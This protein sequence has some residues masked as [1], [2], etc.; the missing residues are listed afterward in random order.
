MVWNPFKIFFPKKFVGI[1]IGTSFIKMVEVSKSGKKKELKNYGSVSSSTLFQRPFRTFEKSTLLLSSYDV[2]K[3]ILAVMDEAGIKTRDV[4]FSIPDFSTFFTN[5]QLPP[6]GK[7]ELPQAVKYE[8][9]QH[10]PL[11]LS[12]VALDWQVVEGSFSKKS[13]AKLDILL[14]A[15]PNDVINQYREI[16]KIAGL[17]LIGLEAEVFGLLRS[18]IKKG[19]TNPLAIVDIGARSTTCSIIEKRILKQSHS[20]DM[21]GNELTELISKELN[22]NFQEAENITKYYGIL[23]KK[24]AGG[25]NEEKLKQILL[26]IVNSIIKEVERIIDKFSTSREKEIKKI[27]LAGWSSLIPGVKEEFAKNFKAEI[28]LANPFSNVSCPPILE[29][30]LKEIG[31]AFAVALGMALGGLEC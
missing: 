3:A 18:L 26:P 28:E 2:A 19:E 4:F 23:G 25:E 27:I 10:V 12:E 22:I 30:T 1:D 11:P 24:D 8:A 6:M 13:S 5:F 7:E 17:K 31:P 15:V 29:D 14:V 16:A 21:S 9:R 20:F